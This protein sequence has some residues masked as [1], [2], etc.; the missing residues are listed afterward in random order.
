VYLWRATGDARLA[1][2]VRAAADTLV[3][4]AT[5]DSGAL[6]WPIPGGL[7][8]T[9]VGEIYH[10]YAHGTAGIGDFL[11][12]AG[13]ASGE[14][15]YTDL[16]R[17][18]AATL[19]ATAVV[20]DGSARWPL[21]PRTTALGGAGWCTG[22]SGIG[23]FLLR[24]WQATGD[25]QYLRLARA[26]AVTVH[27]ARGR[28]NTAA[29]HGIAGSG[30][31][32]LELAAALDEPRYREWAGDLAAVLAARS[33]RRGAYLLVPDE[34]GCGVVADY[35]VGLAGVLAFLVRLRHGG[36]A[37]WTVSYPSPDVRA[38]APAGQHT[39]GMRR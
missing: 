28:D 16:G 13:A 8:S 37:P 19:V 14:R 3:A 9:L 39:G 12:A 30:Q 1:E 11:L 27:R 31:F 7:R 25:A 29:C 6:C 26:A 17:A 34:T 38:E 36:P 22:A 24:A 10:G 23:G 33:V 20:R 5:G 15:R 2:R 32:L 4:A 35:G 18:A 21:G